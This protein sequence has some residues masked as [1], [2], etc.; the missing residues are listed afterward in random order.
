MLVLFLPSIIYLGVSWTRA[1]C[2]FLSI[3]I[4]T[5]D[6]TAV[7]QWLRCCATFGRS[8]VRSQLVSADF[9]L[10]WNPSDRIMAL[11]VDFSFYQ[12]WAPRVFPGGKGSRCVRLTTSDQ[13]V[14]LSWNLGAL[15]SLNPLGLSRSVMGLLYLY[16]TYIH[17]WVCV[18]VCVVL[19]QYALCTAK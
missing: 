6:G 3:Y 15:T 13:P 2:M 4:H 8:L 7:A 11:G 10:T 19:D 9:S 1:L 17:I 12:K 16:L 14:P 5:Y 18:C